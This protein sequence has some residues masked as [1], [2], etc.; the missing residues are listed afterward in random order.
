LDICGLSDNQVQQGRRYCLNQQKRTANRR[1]SET[2]GI[3]MIGE[4]GKSVDCQQTDCI[5]T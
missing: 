2:I 4:A 1:S 5:Q 3:P